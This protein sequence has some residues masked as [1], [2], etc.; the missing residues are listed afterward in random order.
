ME[1][2]GVWNFEVDA[3]KYLNMMKYFFNK[4][5]KYQDGVTSEGLGMIEAISYII[6]SCNEIQTIMVKT[7]S[8]YSKIIISIAGNLNEFSKIK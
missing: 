6:G 8:A 2:G 1:D 5:A 4:S 7:S 3:K